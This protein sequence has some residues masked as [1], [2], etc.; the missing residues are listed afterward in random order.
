M[1]LRCP[2]VLL[3]LLPLRIPGDGKGVNAGSGRGGIQTERAIYGP[4][5]VS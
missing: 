2:L 3:V 1:K 5:L 4:R